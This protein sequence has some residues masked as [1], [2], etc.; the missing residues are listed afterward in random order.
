MIAAAGSDVKVC[1]DKLPLLPGRISV[2]GAGVGSELGDIL[3][4]WEYIDMS[5]GAE[6]R[7]QP[8]GRRAVYLRNE[9]LDISRCNLFTD[10]CCGDSEREGDECARSR[11]ATL[12]P[13]EVA[14]SACH[15]SQARRSSHTAGV[16]GAGNKGCR[17]CTIWRRCARD[18][19]LDA[20]SSRV[21]SLVV[22]VGATSL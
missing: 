4:S 11:H 12:S 7:C 10:W 18:S 14:I 20:H 9:T 16:R 21:G 6:Q 1:S 5:L 13:A 22:L 17:V 3:E 19:F 15:P 8:A 2:E